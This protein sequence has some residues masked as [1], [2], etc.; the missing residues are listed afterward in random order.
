M[1]NENE[2]EKSAAAAGPSRGEKSAAAAA[3]AGSMD[4]KSAAA[5]GPSKAL[6]TRQITFERADLGELEE[7]LAGL[8]QMRGDVTGLDAAN[9]EASIQIY[10]CAVDELRRG[11]VVLVSLDDL[12]IAMTLVEDEGRAAFRAHVE[13]KRKAD[14]DAR[15]E[16]ARLDAGR[17]VDRDDAG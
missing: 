14:D 8:V 2:N 11:G 7:R 6:S 16:K 5:A 15:E 17:S 9:L 4:E 3:A 1:N 12:W 13:W 10:Q